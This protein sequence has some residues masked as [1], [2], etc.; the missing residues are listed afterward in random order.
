MIT[1]RRFIL[2]IAST[3]FVAIEGYFFYLI[4]IADAN[5]D[6]N[7]HYLCIITAATYSWLTLLIELF[8]ARENSESPLKILFSKTEGNLIRIAMLFTLVADYYL[9]GMTEPDNFKGVAVFLGTQLFIFL[10]IFANDQSSKTR[11]VNVLIRFLLTIV[12][13]SVAYLILGDMIDPLAIITLIYFINLCINAIFAH[14]IGRGGI[15]LTVGLILFALCDVNVG[16]AGIEE[17]YITEIS[18]DSLLYNLIHTDV[19]LIWLFYIPSQTLIP[20]TLLFTKK[21]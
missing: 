16:L 5:T 20:L 19:D 11:L 7:L 12:V 9:V 17:M 18:E 2:W 21:K 15:V 4:H 13:I 10:H 1:K 8:T 14:R 6:L 3:I